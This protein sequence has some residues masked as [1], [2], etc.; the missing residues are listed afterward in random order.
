[1]ILTSLDGALIVVNSSS[2]LMTALWCLFGEILA[3][4]LSVFV[5]CAKL[6]T[7]VTD[8]CKKSGLR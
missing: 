4:K 3:G 6:R 1:M 7:I 5:H 8:G 2:H